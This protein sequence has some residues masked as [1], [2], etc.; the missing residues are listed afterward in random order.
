MITTSYKMNQDGIIYQYSN[1][2]IFTKSGQRY[3]I[4]LSCWPKV[5]MDTKYILTIYQ[6]TDLGFQQLVFIDNN[7][8]DL[9]I[10]NNMLK[11]LNGLEFSDNPTLKELNSKSDDIFKQV[12][13]IVG[14]L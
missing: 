12:N 8:T 6:W 14:L 5:N 4:Y 1:E 3:K 13:E 2:Y 7:K 9:I 10:D 11:T